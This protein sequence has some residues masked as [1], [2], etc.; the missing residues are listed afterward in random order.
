MAA[1]ADRSP[2]WA[3]FLTGTGV[4]ISAPMSALP[5]TGIVGVAG[6][7]GTGASAYLT[8]KAA[9]RRIEIRIR[10]ADRRRLEK[11]RLK[12]YCDLLEASRLCREAGAMH[13]HTTPAELN[14]TMRRATVQLLGAA[15]VV[16]LIGSD[17]ARA[18]ADTLLAPARQIA[19]VPPRDTAELQEHVNAVATAEARF[20]AAARAELVP[21]D[22]R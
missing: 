15:H 10:Y 9:E 14:K 17:A 4:R 19:T 2:I 18:A 11:R 13:G 22:A 12:A 5:W 20:V 7:I 8:S 21:P 1:G 16:A 6:I 3:A